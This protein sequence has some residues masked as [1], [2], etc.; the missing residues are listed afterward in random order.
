MRLVLRGFFATGGF[1]EIA[2]A[3]RDGF[4]AAVSG[5]TFSAGFAALF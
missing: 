4:A 1:L 2:R 3:L 5:A